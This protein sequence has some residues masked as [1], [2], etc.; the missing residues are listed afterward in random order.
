MH[1]L[2]LFAIWHLW[3][4]HRRKPSW[5]VKKLLWLVRRLLHWRAWFWCDGCQRS[6]G[7]LSTGRVQAIQE[8][9]TGRWRFVAL[10]FS[11]NCLRTDWVLVPHTA[12]PVLIRFLSK[13]PTIFLYDFYRSFYPGCSRYISEK[14]DNENRCKSTKVTARALHTYTRFVTAVSNP[15]PHIFRSIIRLASNCKGLL[16]CHVT[17]FS[18][19][20]T[21]LLET[22]ITMY[23]TSS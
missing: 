8:E 13:S 6:K 11:G 9:E 14:D 20:L 12:Q 2:W 10:C 21:H 16:K 19:N 23:L 4:F 3:R 18:G 5:S 7:L 1:W 15:D 22:I 17:L